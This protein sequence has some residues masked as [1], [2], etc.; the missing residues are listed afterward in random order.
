MKYCLCCVN[1]NFIYFD[2]SQYSIFLYQQYV[3]ENCLKKKEKNISHS[4]VSVKKLQKGDEKVGIKYSSTFELMWIKD[5]KKINR[6]SHCLCLLLTQSDVTFSAKVCI[7]VTS[8]SC[9]ETRVKARQCSVQVF[10]FFSH[11]IYPAVIILVS[12]FVSILQFAYSNVPS[13]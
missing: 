7:N 9:C 13:Y 1:N 5:L 12:V 11:T 4:S 3:E 2:S 6:G 10:F 8:S